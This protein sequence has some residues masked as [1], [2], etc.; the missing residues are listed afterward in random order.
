MP[1]RRYSHHAINGEFIT[2]DDLKMFVAE[3]EEER[4][5]PGTAVIRFRSLM[6]ISLAH[7]PRAHTVTAEAEPSADDLFAEEPAMAGEQQHS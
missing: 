2:L 7:G 4:G 3:M 6:E 1:L 5:M